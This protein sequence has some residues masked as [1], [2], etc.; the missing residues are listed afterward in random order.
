MVFLAVTLGHSLFAAMIVFI[1]SVLFGL[2]SWKCAP[3]FLKLK[4]QL[5]LKKIPG[6]TF[7]QIRVMREELIASLKAFLS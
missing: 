5:E 3:Y 4:F 7:Q 1:L 6:S 2:M